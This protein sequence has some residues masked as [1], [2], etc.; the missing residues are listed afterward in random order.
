[1]SLYHDLTS[2]DTNPPAWATS[3]HVW[4]SLF[5][6]ILVPLCFL[7]K[8]DSLRHTS[9]VAMFSVGELF[10][11]SRFYE[12]GLKFNSCS[13]L[14]HDCHCLLL[15]PSSWYADQRGGASDKLF[16][17]LYNHFPR[18]SLCVHVRPERTSCLHNPATSC[19]DGILKQLFPIYNELYDN[20]QKRM[21][22]V[23]TSAIGSAA[24][25]YEVIAVFGYLTF[26][27]NVRTFIISYAKTLMVIFRWERISSQCTRQRLFLLRSDNL[28]SS[29]LSSS[30]TLS[31]SCHVETASTRCSR[32]GRLLSRSLLEMS[33]KT[34]RKTTNSTMK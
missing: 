16:A 34:M 18:A 13:V 6:I 29:S 19:I 1:M 30:R 31:K 17:E 25:T 4:I 26:G 9:Y 5:M 28:P 12:F 2:L 24:M 7:R 11:R 33:W 23:I 22:V 10:Q 21:N 14:G 20:S 27:S 15:L 8:I 3:G 32:T